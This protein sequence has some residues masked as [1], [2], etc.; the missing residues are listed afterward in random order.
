MGNPTH[1]RRLGNDMLVINDDGT[2]Y[3]A[4]STQGDLWL[5]GAKIPDDTA[6]ATG[7]GSGLTLGPIPSTLT[8]K[9]KDD[10]VVTL[11]STQLNHA[12]QIIKNAAQNERIGRKG[13]LIALMA[14]LTESSLLMYANS[15]VPDSTDYPHDAVGSDHDSLGLFQMRPSTGWGSVK[16]LM[17]EDYNAKAFFGGPTGPNYPSPRG[18]LD[19]N[20]WATMDPGVVCQAVEVSAFPDRYQNYQP[21][22]QAILDALTVTEKPG[23]IPPTS[24][25]RF[26]WPFPLTVVTSE[27]GM[28]NG[29]LHAGMDFAGGPAVAG[30][31]IPASANGIVENTWTVGQHGGYGNVVLLNHGGGLF[32]LYAHMQNNSFMV[33]KGQ[34]VHQGDGLGRLGNTGQSYGAHLHFETHEG[35]YRWDASSVNPRVFIPKWNAK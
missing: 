31:V 18:M 22:A 7:S 1:V 14:A 3:R 29:R 26:I 10:T 5:V 24:G 19:I 9:A 27:Y 28:R 30:A 15:N 8:A 16:N 6:A 17:D 33:H 23:T 13:A 12:G 21:V 4:R 2:K 34:T 35:G 32:T 25:T 11:N 20:G